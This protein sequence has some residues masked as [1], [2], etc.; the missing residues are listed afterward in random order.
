M[1]VATKLEGVQQPQSWRFGEQTFSPFTSISIFQ[2]INSM[3]LH[4]WRK[5]IKTKKIGTFAL[6]NF[7]FYV[8]ANLL[9]RLRDFHLFFKIPIFGHFGGAKITKIIKIAQCFNS[10]WHSPKVPWQRRFGFMSIPLTVSEEIAAQNFKKSTISHFWPFAATKNTKI[11]Q[12]FFIDQF[13][14][15][16]FLRSQ[17]YRCWV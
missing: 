8:T 12:F 5:K 3:M 13:D 2:I 11:D 16:L 7:V 17:K 15:E 10:L 1:P 6:S 4:S 14:L 9:G